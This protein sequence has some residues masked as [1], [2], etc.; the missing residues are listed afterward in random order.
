MSEMQYRK[1]GK[2]DWK[3][4]AL[5]FGNLWLPEVNHD[6]NV[7]NEPVATQMLRYAIDHG[8]N[9]IDTAFDYHNGASEI[10]VGK[11]L[12][13]GYR[14][15]VKLAS[16]M[17]TW[18]IKTKDDFDKY[19]DIQLRKLQT[20][21]L[22]FYL[23]H[24]LDKKKW[25]NLT[26]LNVI[27]WAE[28]AIGEGLIDHLGF[29]F[30]DNIDVF[31]E[32]IDYHDWTFTQIVYNYVDFK[33]EAGQEGLRYAASKGLAV[34][35]MTPIQSGYIGITP[36]PEVQATWDEMPTKRSPAEWAL[37]WAWNQSEVSVVLSGMNAMPQVVENVT[38]AGRSGVGT[39]SE[40][41]LGIIE[42]VRQKYLEIGLVG[43]IK[44]NHCSGCPEGVAIPEIIDLFNEYYTRDIYVRDRVPE[45]DPSKEKYAKIP[46]E[47]KGDK[48]SKCDFC[49][50]V[51]P[52]QL[53]IIKLMKNI[54]RMM[55]RKN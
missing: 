44:C 40:K 24:T 27:D 49:E 16:K 26:N 25:D 54:S 5:G 23:L 20:D 15:K 34:N 17:P 36:L 1:Y 51:C 14:E 4:S 22:D 39:L 10:A 18:L 29:S 35:V 53:P 33:R 46:D 3:V 6:Y 21:K 7:V 12:L 45:D 43:C 48:C 11:A 47:N 19:L 38:S 37:Q 31:K 28:K 13:D 55:G 42:R 52:Q 2:L 30:H 41:E 9:Y 8:V 32:I 50:D